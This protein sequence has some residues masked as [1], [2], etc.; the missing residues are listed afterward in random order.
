MLMNPPASADWNS[1]IFFEAG[2]LEVVQ[3]RRRLPDHYHRVALV[4]LDLGCAGDGLLSFFHHLPENLGFRS[5]PITVVDLSGQ[6]LGEGIFEVHNFLVQHQRFNRLVCLHQ[7]C[8]ARSFVHTSGLDADVAVFH[9]IQRYRLRGAVQP[10]GRPRQSAA[11]WGFATRS[12]N[13]K[14]YDMTAATQYSGHFGSVLDGLGGTPKWV[15]TLNT[16]YTF[17]KAMLSLQTLLPQLRPPRLHGA[18]RHPPGRPGRQELQPGQP[19]HDQ[20]QQG[21]EA[22]L[23]NPVKHL[24]HREERVD[25][26]QAAGPL[27]DPQLA[28]QGSADLRRHRQQQPVLRRLRPDLPGR[29]PLR[30]LQGDA[31]VGG[32]HGAATGD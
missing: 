20:R 3:G 13:L 30:A 24:R 18:A 12:M 11:A 4:E 29:P 7:D 10:A 28:G 22:R 5:E 26:P 9:H 2:N 31:V 1:D 17:W 15:G 23:L 25:E 6:L 32:P 19:E 16:T 21:Q 14:N 8:Y 27:H